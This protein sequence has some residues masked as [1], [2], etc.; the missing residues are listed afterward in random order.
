LIADH[1]TAEAPIQTVG[2]GRKVD[3]WKLRGPGRDNHWLDCIVGAAVAAS[4]NGSALAGVTDEQPKQKRRKIT[5]AEWRA[6]RGR[7]T[8]VVR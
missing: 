8:A 1:I 4:M 7:V 3:E 2:R 6:K 5:I